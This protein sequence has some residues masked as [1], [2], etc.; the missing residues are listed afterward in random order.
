[1]A[2]QILQELSLGNFNRSYKS[3]PVC[4]KELVGA[5]PGSVFKVIANEDLH[6][7]GAHIPSRLLDF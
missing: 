3:L 4:G 5:I 7:M 6:S 1:M 2:K